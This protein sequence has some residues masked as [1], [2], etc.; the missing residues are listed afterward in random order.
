M[1]FHLG[2]IPENPEFLPDS[3]WRPLREPTPLVMQFLAL[4]LGIAACIA[5]GV[6]WLFL[7]PLRDISLDSLGMLLIAFV[8]IIP[9]AIIPIHELL[10]AAVHPRLGLSASSILGFWPSQ[11]LFY[12]HYDGELSR[13]R[14]I[15]ILLMPLLIIS[16]M[17]LFACAVAGRSSALLAFT[18]ALNALFACGDM[19][20]VGLLLF[21]V[22]SDAT[23]RNQGYKTFWKIHDAKAA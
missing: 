4:P 13:G 2:A 12:A 20:G 22:P 21:Q 23:V 18:S 19:F 14:F 11:G 17:P 7:T 3:S 1:R 15:A 9:I 8:A 6:L 10:H 5:V 16:I